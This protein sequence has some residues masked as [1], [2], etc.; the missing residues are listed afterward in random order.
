VRPLLEA[1]GHAVIAP[2]LPSDR[3]DAGLDAYVDTV[4]DAM[5]AVPS[6][7]RVVVVGQSLGG[8][9]APVV[10][11]R[12]RV[13]LLVL[14]GAMIALPHERL[15]E[16]WGHTGWEAARRELLVRDGRSPD[17]GF[18]PIADFFDDVPDPVVRAAM[19]RGERKQSGRVFQDRWPLDAW[20][21]VPTR[22][23]IGRDDRFFPAPFM[24]RVVRERLGIVPDEIDG[25]HLPALAR[26][27]ELVERLEA[28]RREVEGPPR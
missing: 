15:G 16:W 5:R 23:L 6:G 24:R 20:P 12:T 18:D 26:P 3:D 17:A 7:A 1:R 21:D 28:Y 13:D 19:A 22:V 4:L 25:G 9:T 8:F 27:D 14:V 11:T 2:D 10:C